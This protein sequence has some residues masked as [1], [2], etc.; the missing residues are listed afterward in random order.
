MKKSLLTLIVSLLLVLCML[1]SCGSETPDYSGA[2]GGENYNGVDGELSTDNLPDDRKMAITANYTIESLE[3][4]NAV[5]ALEAAVTQAGGYVGSSQITPSSEKRQ[6][7]AKYVI[8]IPVANTDAFSK[9]LNGIGNII[10]RSMTTNDVTL[11]YTDISA[12]IATLEAQ[13]TRVRAL[14]GNASS[15]SELL[16]LEKRLT[17]ISSELTSL[18]NQL[19]TLENKVNYSTFNITLKDVTEYSAPEEEETGF[20]KELGQNFV[21]AFELFGAI[22]SVLLMIVVYLLPFALT[23]G[24]IL[25]LIYFLRRRKAKKQAKVAA[26]NQAEEPQSPSDNQGLFS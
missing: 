16:T 5:S 7:S 3:F 8:R 24:I 6:G 25:G 20:F 12:R 26:D 22:L 18:K 9:A 10:S 4:N 17:E 15:T 14:M 13:E 11:T 1:V 21:S 19:A 23:A 2:A